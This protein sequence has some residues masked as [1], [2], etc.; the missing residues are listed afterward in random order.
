MNRIRKH[1]IELFKI[2]IK[3]LGSSEFTNSIIIS[4]SIIWIMWHY[5]ILP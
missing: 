4:M 5:K 3:L 2:P 1:Y